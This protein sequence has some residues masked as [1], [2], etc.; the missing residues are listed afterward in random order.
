MVEEM[1]RA[2]D[3][4]HALAHGARRS[5]LERL[6]SGDL[7]VGEL[8]APLD[9]SLAAASKHILVLERAG[10]VSRRVVGTRHF[11]RLSPA[12]LAFAAAWL[13]HYERFWNVRLD[14]LADLFTENPPS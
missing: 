10:L 12:P 8:A 3:V 14:A 7:T 13:S 9:M 11:C 4:F 1:E 6:S 5:M 2:T